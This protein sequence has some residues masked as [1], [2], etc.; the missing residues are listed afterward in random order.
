[1]IN[2]LVITLY[3]RFFTFFYYSILL[4]GNPIS[5]L[6]KGFN[7]SRYPV[8][9][10]IFSKNEK[11]Y[12]DPNLESYPAMVAEMNVKILVRYSDIVGY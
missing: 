1:M 3:S 7:V 6:A 4:L 2:L 5:M 9:K 10:K 11:K 8:T 12:I